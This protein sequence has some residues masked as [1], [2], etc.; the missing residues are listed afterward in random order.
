MDDTWGTSSEGDEDG[1]KEKSDS[2]EDGPDDKKNESES[3]SEHDGK[4][5]YGTGRSTNATKPEDHNVGKEEGGA[6]GGTGGIL[7]T[8]SQV[9]SGKV[10]E[11]L[12]PCARHCWRAPR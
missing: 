6:G 11:T 5:L 7:V 8:Y 3:E 12:R 1:N 2:E 4:S 9:E 10:V